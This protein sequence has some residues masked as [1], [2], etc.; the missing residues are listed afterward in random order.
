MRLHRALARLS[1]AGAVLLFLAFLAGARYV[2]EP[3]RAASGPGEGGLPVSGTFVLALD[4]RD[5]TRS[6]VFWWAG[7][8]EDPVLLLH[9]GAN[10]QLAV[11][12]VAGRLYLADTRGTG[13]AV[14]DYLAVYEVLSPA[15]VSKAPGLKPLSEVTVTDRIRYKEPALVPYVALRPGGGPVYLSAGSGPSNTDKAA[16]VNGHDPKSLQVTYQGGRFP[17]LQ[18]PRP[19][20]PWQEGEIRVVLWS[21]NQFLALG[22]GGGVVRD[23]TVAGAGSM[24][25]PMV[26]AAALAPDGKRVYGFQARRL[27]WFAW[28]KSFSRD[29]EI[30]LPEGWQVVRGAAALSADGR[31]VL[32]GVAPREQAAQG[33]VREVWMFDAETGDAVRKVDLEQG[34][35]GFLPA[36]DGPYLLAWDRITEGLRRLDMAA[37]AAGSDQT[38][39]RTWSSRLSGWAPIWMAP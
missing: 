15:G 6:A 20:V 16:W 9:A 3:F 35:D 24:M 7:W 2:L 28:D 39:G 8:G 25:P 10:P 33:R 14:E 18:A 34:V 30:V 22:R 17:G 4:Q 26:R 23:W 13:L 36:R 31:Q 27:N 37:A 11:D 38:A 1:L 5:Y 21:G 12:P 19:L 29:Q 32:V